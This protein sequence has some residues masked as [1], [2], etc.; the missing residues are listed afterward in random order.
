LLVY[1]AGMIDK[2][3]IDKCRE[4]RHKII[5]HYSNWKNSGKN[6]GTLCFLNPLNGEDKFSKDGLKSNLPPS[7]I[8]MKDYNAIKKCDL[9]I[10]NMETFNVQRAPIGTISEISLA[11]EMRKPIFMIT[12]DKT[13]RRH[14]FISTM[15]SWYFTSVDDMLKKKAINIFYKAFNSAPY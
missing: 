12:T 15:V 2:K 11:Y 13:Y 9:F 5:A 4:W 6:Y 3:N 8:F 7:A 1:L 10:V 14:P